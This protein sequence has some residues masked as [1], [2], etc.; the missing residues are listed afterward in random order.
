VTAHQVLLC[1][2]AGTSHLSKSTNE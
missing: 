2:V 1:N